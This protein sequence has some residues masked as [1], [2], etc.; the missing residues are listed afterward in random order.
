MPTNRT[1]SARKS[2]I[3]LRLILSLSNVSYNGRQTVFVNRQTNVL[4]DLHHRLYR[5]TRRDEQDQYRDADLG[6]HVLPNSS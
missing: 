6:Y 3:S 4:N 2:S 1:D 5:Q